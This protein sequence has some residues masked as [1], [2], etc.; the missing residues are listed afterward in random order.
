MIHIRF[1]G[2]SYDLD[3]SSLGMT[4]GRRYN[5]GEVL[6][7]VARQLDIT[8]DRLGSHVVDRGPGGQIVVRPEAV[9]G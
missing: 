2:R 1:D 4:A 3:E 7:R 6:E 5:D 8:P 9:Y